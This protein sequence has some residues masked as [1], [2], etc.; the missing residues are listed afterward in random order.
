[1]TGFSYKIEFVKVINNRVANSLLCYFNDSKNT[2]VTADKNIDIINWAE[3]FL[4]VDF[5]QIRAEI[6]KDPI[7]SKVIS[8]IIGHW[9]KEIS[10]EIKPY[11]NRHEEII[12]EWDVLILGYRT[13][14]IPNQLKHIVLKELHSTH[15]GVVKMKALHSTK[16][17]NLFNKNR[18]WFDKN[19]INNNPINNLLI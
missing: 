15:M 9:P 1:M 3:E 4:T 2:P 14:F 17:N 18:N 6:L 13:Y 16:N 19:I 7:I 10:N 12:I 5:L 11:Y 8:Y